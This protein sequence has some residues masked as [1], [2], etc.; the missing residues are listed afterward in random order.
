MPFTGVF[1]P[2]TSGDWIFYM[3][4][5]DDGELWL[6]PMGDDITGLQ[7]IIAS[8]SCCHPFSS[9][10]SPAI[11]LAAGQRYAIMGI[12]KEGGGGDY[13]QVAAK[14]ASDP[15][16]PD[17]LAPI[18]GAYLQVL[19]DPVNASLVITQQPQSQVLISD[20]ILPP[21]FNF[22]QTS[23][24]C[25]VANQRNPPYPWVWDYL[26]F[27]TCHGDAN[28]GGPYASGLQTP[29]V[30]ITNTDP[31]T[32]TFVHRHS[33]EFDA[34][35]NYDGGQ[36]QLSVNGSPFAVVPGTS[37]TANGY[38]GLI[39]G[40]TV[41]ADKSAFVQASAGYDTH[42][43]IASTFMIGPFNPGDQVQVQ[44]IAS[45]DECS[46]A[47]EPNW[48]IASVVFSSG[49]V[50]PQAGAQ[51]SV[52]ALSYFN[53]ALNG[54]YFYE[55][56]QDSGGGFLD[57]AGQHSSS[58]SVAHLPLGSSQFRC[59]VYTPGAQA[60]TDVATVTTTLPVNIQYNSGF[61]LVS[62]SAGPTG[63]ELQKKTGSVGPTGWLTVPQ[64]LYVTNGPSVSFTES[65]VGNAFY[66]LRRP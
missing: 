35:A 19:L 26:N 15:T 63:F 29:P 16:N 42:A 21:Q 62:W 56:Q 34:S 40:T 49:E 38:N 14:L 46:E 53:G 23:G 39:G 31:V 45:W 60:T 5:D 51:L 41:L 61:V 6:N 58:L 36:V 33:F 27:W 66:R 48:Q 12:Y 22:S 59:I 4:N 37:F 55:W 17:L 54:Q 44:F 10:A 32:V 28:C 24:H 30:V 47:A 13:M 52:G 64:N 18:P 11:A 2:P 9:N 8:P 65:A 50:L 57:L 20:P 7:R 43:L 1:V 3:S 25:S